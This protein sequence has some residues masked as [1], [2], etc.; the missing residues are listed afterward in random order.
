M[1]ARGNIPVALE[2][3]RQAEALAPRSHEIPLHRGLIAE[4]QGRSP[5]AFELYREAVGRNPSDPQAKARLAEVAARLRRWEIAAPMFASLLEMG[6]HPSRAHFGLGQAAE[7]RCDKPAASSEYR[8]ALALDPAFEP[9]R[10]A[11]A[12]LDA[13]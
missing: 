9:A 11:L 3:I 8:R 2:R 5:E 6:W 12:R 13:R 10:A 7:A 1:A 4:G